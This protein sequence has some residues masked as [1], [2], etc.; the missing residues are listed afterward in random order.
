MTRVSNMCGIY[1]IYSIN[2]QT[3]DP[4]VLPR[5][6]DRM[7]HRGPDDAGEYATDRLVMGMRRLSII[8]LSGGHQP[9]ANEDKTV[10]A[11]CNGEIYNFRE[12]REEL[13]A[14]GHQF[15]TAS[16]SEVLVHLYEQFGDGF[17]ERLSGMFGVP[18]TL[19]RPSGGSI[20]PRWGR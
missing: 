2:G 6:G 14:L 11:V 20:R 1:G 16:D 4:G 8:D 18:I 5:M 7:R 17:V 13:K 19:E 12:L 10:W 15:A 9:I 3:P